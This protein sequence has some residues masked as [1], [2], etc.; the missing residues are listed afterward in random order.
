MNSTSHNPN[1]LRR[2]A[3]IAADYLNLASRLELLTGEDQTPVL[4]RN[5]TD[6]GC[7]FAIQGNSHAKSTY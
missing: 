7:K 4:A 3:T 1:S 5:Q 6:N 2:L